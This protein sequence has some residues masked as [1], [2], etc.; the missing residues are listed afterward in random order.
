MTRTQRHII[1]IRQ[2]DAS[3]QIRDA[4]GRPCAG[5]PISVEQ[6]SHA[7]QFG[8]IVPDL[9]CFAEPDRDRYRARLDDVFNGVMSR[10]QPV[11]AELGILRVDVAEPIPLGR[12]RLRLDERATAG[13]PLQV[14]VWGK[15]L[16]L[17]ETDGPGPDERD[18]GRRVAEFY[19][20]CFAHPAVRGIFWHGFADGES[21]MGGGGLLRRDLAPKYAY[22]VLQ[23]LIGFDWHSRAKGMTDATGQFRFRGFFGDYRIV[24]GRG[25]TSPLVEMITLR[26]GSAPFAI[27]G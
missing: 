1:E 27:P 5:I 22:K 16:G 12:L 8:C 6:E 13:V 14:H 10:R 19:T 3:I 21:G 4:L 26:R 20:L 11:N 2:G 17:V 23:K 18:A 7:F 15:S 25:E 24:A 9:T